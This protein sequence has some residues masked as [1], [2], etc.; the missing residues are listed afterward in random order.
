VVF[1]NGEC[2]ILKSFALLEKTPHVPGLDLPGLD[3]ESL[4]T[5]FG[6]RS[7][8]VDGTDGLTKEFNAALEAGGPTVIVVHT[9]PELPFLG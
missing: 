3:I 4:G 1:R 6:L 2:A 5:G 9:K 8:T 7:V